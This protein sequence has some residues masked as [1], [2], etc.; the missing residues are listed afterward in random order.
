VICLWCRE[1]IE[2]RAKHDPF[3]CWFALLCIEARLA[4]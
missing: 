3:D 2:V 4:E 1:A